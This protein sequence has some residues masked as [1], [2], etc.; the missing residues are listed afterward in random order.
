MTSLV[1]YFGIPW[2]MRADRLIGMLL[3]LQTQGRMTAGRLARE[4]EVSRRTILRDVEALG[5]AGVPIVSV[6]GPGGGI[7]LVEGF[8]TELTGLN[9]D[10]SS[11]L[12]LAGL[13][14]VAADLG[15]HDA[16]SAARRKLLSAL[17]PDHQSLATALQTWLYVEPSREESARL[18]PRLVRAIRER[19]AIRV[20]VDDGQTRKLLPLGLV[21]AAGGWH[22]VN[23]GEASTAVASITGLRVLSES[24]ER[25]PDFVLE[26]SWNG[27]AD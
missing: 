14:A 12:F 24:F 11:V 3:L 25:P 6:R 16:A 2:K 5:L 27:A 10:E 4:L 21:L 7:E 26:S 13:P 1:T 19:R 22:L 23:V 15:V 8:R 20:S 18:L 17:A 9:A